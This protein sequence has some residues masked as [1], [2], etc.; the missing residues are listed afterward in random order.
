ME[1]MCKNCG[2]PITK[3]YC[4]GYPEVCEHW[5]PKQPKTNADRIRAMS[6]EELSK[7]L[8]ANTECGSC[9]WSKMEGCTLT[10]WLKQ[11]AE[12]E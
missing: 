11:T 9:K 12:V 1:K 3:E 2:S 8:C 5:T 6:D 4:E 7:F 10:E